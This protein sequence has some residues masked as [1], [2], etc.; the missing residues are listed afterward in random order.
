LTFCFELDFDLV[1]LAIQKIINI[2]NNLDTISI[3]Y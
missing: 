2:K 3:T 1:D